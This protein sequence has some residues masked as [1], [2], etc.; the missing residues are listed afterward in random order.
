MI[1]YKSLVWRYTIGSSTVPRTVPPLHWQKRRDGA[2]YKQIENIE[3]KVGMRTHLMAGTPEETG[4]SKYFEEHRRKSEAGQD[5]AAVAKAKS[6][7]SSQLS[8]WRVWLSGWPHQLKPS[9]PCV[10]GL[11]PE[12]G[13][14]VQPAPNGGKKTPPRG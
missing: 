1:W 5:S 9:W 10:E 12:E 6:H 2:R 11:T 3:N 7:R 8:A 4:T 13:S 14:G